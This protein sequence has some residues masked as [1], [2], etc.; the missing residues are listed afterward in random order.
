MIPTRQTR[1]ERKVFAQIALI[2]LFAVQ[3]IINL[4]QSA[5]S[6]RRLHSMGNGWLWL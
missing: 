6:M 4:V 5:T 2:I 3:L 1:Q